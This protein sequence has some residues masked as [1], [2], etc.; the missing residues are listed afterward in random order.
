MVVKWNCKGVIHKVR[1]QSI[2]E[3]GNECWVSEIRV[4]DTNRVVEKPNGGESERMKDNMLLRES[5]RNE[6]WPSINIEVAL[7]GAQSGESVTGPRNRDSAQVQMGRSYGFQREALLRAVVAVVRKRKMALEEAHT[8]LQ[9][10]KKIEDGLR[11]DEE[12]GDK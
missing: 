11:R 4:V 9:I 6:T 8:T 2:N 3:N 5:R 7:V 10:G 1:H 12:R